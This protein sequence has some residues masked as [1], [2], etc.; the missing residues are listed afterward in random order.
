[1][2]L[3][4]ASRFCLN[5][6]TIKTLGFYGNAHLLNLFNPKKAGG[7]NLTLPLWFFQK[8]VLYREGETLFSL[9]TFNI[10]ISHIFSENFIEIPKVDKKIWGFLPP[11]VD[12]SDFFK[13]TNDVTYDR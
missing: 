4:F 10:I 13:E 5:D 12:F 1:M 3:D 9:V 11:F 6:K 7:V 8:Y 2:L